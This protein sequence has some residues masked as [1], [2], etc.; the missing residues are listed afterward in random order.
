M[1]LRREVPQWQ[2][3]LRGEDEDRQRRLEADPALGESH[4][5][6]DGHERD[7]ERRG[8]IEHGAREE[9]DPECPHRR[10]AV[11]LAHLDD[12]FRLRLR[13]VE[14][15]QRGQPAHDVEEVVR[16]ERERLPALPR[17]PLR[18]TPDEPHEHGHEREGQEHDSRREEI[19]RR[20]QDEH[21]DRDDDREND[22]R[23]VARE[24]R[25]Q[26]VD[27]GDCGRRDLRAL[28]AVE[29]RRLPSKPRLDD[30]EPKLGD[31][32]AGRPPAGDLEAPR[33]ERPRR[34]DSDEDDAAV[35]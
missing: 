3:E 14:R 1:K 4:T 16:E 9:R 31:H 7:R 29:R 18:L 12:P 35:S 8:E 10:P 34:D 33:G 20:D 21:G 13:A 22:L 30:V 15:A 26:R 11:L 25:L 19:D 32:V 5:H 17:A 24:R 23:E 28:S 6:D 27:A 2:V